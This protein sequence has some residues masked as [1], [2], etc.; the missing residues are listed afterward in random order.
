MTMDERKQAQDAFRDTHRVLI[1][2]DAGGG[3]NLQFAHVYSTTIFLGIQCLEQRIGRVDRIGQLKTV[4]AINFVFEDSVEFRV[5]EVLEQ[6]LAVIFGEFGIDK[7]GDVLDSAQAG[8]LFEDVFTSAFLN[9]DSIESSVEQTI[10]KIR[11]EVQEVH[12]ASTIYGV[13]DEPDTYSAERLRTHP[14][15]FW[16]ARMTVAYLNAYGGAASS[17]RSW[18]NL[19]WPDG[20]KD[21]KAVFN[22]TDASRLTDAALLN[23][24]NS[25]V[26]GLALN[27]PQVAAGQP[28]PSVVVSGLPASI[29]GL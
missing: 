14:L 25:R 2:T 8:E 10:T 4:R 27:L 13:S 16:V 3:L 9:P 19:E 12:S 15:P 29:S 18:W 22:S 6:K 7:T 5:R 1:S 28:L 24:E 20:H 26:R 17:K 21:H 23:L 11:D